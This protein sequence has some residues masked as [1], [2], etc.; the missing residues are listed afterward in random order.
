[1]QDAGKWLVIIG[2]LILGL[3]MIF[4]F[5]G[6]KF[7]WIGHLPGDIRIERDNFKFYFPLTTMVLF[8]I[9]I[10][11]VIRLVKWITVYLQS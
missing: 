11:V 9:V 2:A 6:D 5:W 3:G 7:Q 4:Y 10:N 8:S 1:M